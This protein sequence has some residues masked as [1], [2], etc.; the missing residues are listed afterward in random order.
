MGHI[1]PRERSMTLPIS[2]I[3]YKPPYYNGGGNNG[4]CDGMLDVAAKP[5]R[6]GDVKGGESI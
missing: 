5:A 6:G 1:W 2:D 4:Y 3:P